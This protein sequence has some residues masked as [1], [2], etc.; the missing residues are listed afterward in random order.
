MNQFT[1]AIQKAAAPAPSLFARSKRQDLPGVLG[2]GAEAVMEE[3]NA[4]EEALQ[5][6]VARGEGAKFHDSAVTTYG[7]QL[8]AWVDMQVDARLGQLL[9]NFLEGEFE[10]F[11][12]EYVAAQEVASTRLE[13]ELQ[14]VADAQAKLLQVVDSMSRELARVKE[15]K[16][17]SRE[18]WDVGQELHGMTK[19]GEGAKVARLDEQAFVGSSGRH[20]RELLDALGEGSRHAQG[21][22]KAVTA[23]WQPLSSNRIYVLYNHRAALGLLKVGP[24]RLFVSRGEKE[25]LVEISPLCVL[26]FYVVEGHQRGGMGRQLFDQMLSRED[27]KA[28]R[29][30]YDRPSPK[31]IGFLRKHFGLVQY[32]PQANHFVVFDKYWSSQR[33]PSGTS[34]LRHLFQPLDPG[35]MLRLPAPAPYRG[36]NADCGRRA[37]CWKLSIELL[38]VKDQVSAFE[39]QL[40]TCRSEASLEEGSL[41]DL[42]AWADRKFSTEGQRIQGLERELSNAEA[43]LNALVQELNSEAARS[44]LELESVNSEAVLATP[45]DGFGEPPTKVWLLL[46]DL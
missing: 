24:K 4:L 1:R 23:G 12:S 25:G 44:K 35:P 6:T 45:G 33:R 8:R 39:R 19:H 28:E 3:V 15:E 37:W 27:V 30:G 29:L 41:K 18:A 20:V 16:A 40:Q 46:W 38:K 13:G 7:I 2:E 31:L 43:R 36:L 22:G 34:N 10:T 5:Q 14:A 21:L 42:S 26:D 9:P 32:Q 17:T 11:R